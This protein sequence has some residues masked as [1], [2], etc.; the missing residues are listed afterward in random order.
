[1]RK[2]KKITCCSVSL[3][4]LLAIVLFS[5]SK[6]RIKTNNAPKEYE[7]ANINDY[8]DSKKQIEQEFVIDSTAKPDPIVG[9]QKTHIWLN[10]ECLMFSNGDTITYP[11]VV[12]LVELYT[13]ADMIYYRMPT[14]ASDV[15]LQTEGEIRLRAFK[16]NVELVL[17]PGCSP[18]IIMPSKAPLKDMRV[19]Y[20]FSASTFVDWTDNPASLGINTTISPIFKTDTLGYN[21]F[22]AKLGWINCG[23]QKGGTINHI[24]NFT[25]TT[26]VL[27]NVDIFLYFP[28]TKTVMQAYNSA[29]GSIPDGSKVK[30]VALG[31]NKNGDLFSFSQGVIVNTSGP[32]DITLAATTDSDFTNLLN[33]L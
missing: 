15:I 6:D 33:G 11:Y 14:V 9:N 10:K 27:T 3:L 20:G 28:D 31:V 23:L 17:K 12:K 8:L 25:S 29:S 21:A 5:C 13:P 24:L 2:N 1:M 7:A 16:N 30:I 26:D 4:A 19:F 18:R 32:I 22:I